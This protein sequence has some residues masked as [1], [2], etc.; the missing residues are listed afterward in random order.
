MFGRKGEEQNGEGRE[1]VER[2]DASY[3]A[4]LEAGIRKYAWKKG[5]VEYVGDHPKTRNPV[6]LEDA[7]KEAR[8]VSDS[9]ASKD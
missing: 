1:S 5:G 6:R 9:D 7:L 2:D 8:L 4:G 3:A